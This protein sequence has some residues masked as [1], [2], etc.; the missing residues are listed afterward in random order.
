MVGTLTAGQFAIYGDIKKVLGTLI[1]VGSIHLATLTKS[2]LQVP[3]VVSRSPSRDFAK[4]TGEVDVMMTIPKQDIRS[5]SWEMRNRG[6]DDNVAPRPLCDF[7]PFYF[8][9]QVDDAAPMIIVL[10]CI[11]RSQS[12]N[13]LD[14]FLVPHTHTHCFG[15]I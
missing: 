9:C 3:L 11:F 6:E 15:R 4:S 14:F 10:A 13:A 8:A 5:G 1:L 12:G 7:W 2:C